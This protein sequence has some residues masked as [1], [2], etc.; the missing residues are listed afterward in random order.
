[1]GIIKLWKTSANVVF[2]KSVLWLSILDAH[3]KD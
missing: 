3:K 2:L 1:M